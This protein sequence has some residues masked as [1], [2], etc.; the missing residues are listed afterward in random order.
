MQ[1]FAQAKTDAL[2]KSQASAPA[3]VT[4]CRQRDANMLKVLE[5]SLEL[6]F[7]ASSG[8]SDSVR[9][10]ERGKRDVCGVER[11]LPMARGARCVVS[12]CQ[13]ITDNSSGWR[14]FSL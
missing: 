8:I 3:E 4:R 6:Q 5:S 11:G 12:L 1:N 14:V 13:S 9:K 2:E 10:M 7:A